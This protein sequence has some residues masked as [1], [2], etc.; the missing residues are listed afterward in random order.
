F[1]EGNVVTAYVRLF[2]SRSLMVDESTITGESLPVIKDHKA[3]ISKDALVYELKNTLLSGTTVVKGEGRAVVTK[4]ADG[5]Y[6]ASIAEGKEKS[7]KTP[8]TKATAAFSKRYVAVLIILFLIV[9]F[10]GFLQARSWLNLAYILIAELVSALP[11]G[12]PIVVTSVLVVGA[13]KLSRKKTL[14]RY[15]P[16]VETLGSATIIATDKTGTIT[17]GKLI[18]KEKFSLDEKMTNIIASLANDAKE[19]L[20]DP[21]DIAL[22][23]SIDDFDKIKKKYPQIKS[24]PFDVNLRSMA[25]VNEVDGRNKLFIKGAY[26][27]LKKIAQNTKEFKSLEEN[28]DLMSKKGLR[29]IALGYGEYNDRDFKDWKINIVGLIG[30]LDPPKEGV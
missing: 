17:E 21:L 13:R 1:Y 22:K 11:E 25:S 2:D 26:E 28:L 16:S 10:V 15:L 6:F 27:S 3:K 12:L 4:T 8:L 29:T 19:N 23:N 14:V 24:Y 18:V 20:G 9:G 7:P 5:T 30:F